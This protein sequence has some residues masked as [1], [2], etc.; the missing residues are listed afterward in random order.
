MLPRFFIDRPIFAW[1]IALGIL[2]AGILVFPKLPVSQYPDVAPPA[3][4]ITATYPGASAKVVEDTV[5]TLIEQEMNGI[6]NLLYMESNSDATGTLALTMTFATGTDLDI[7][8]VEAQNRIK[9]VESRL[10]EEVRRQGIVVTKARRNY[11]VFL[12]VFSPDQSRNAVDLG[13]FVAANVLDPIRR[14]PGVG[15]AQLFGT[16]YAM[17][18]WLDPLKLANYGMSPGQALAAV[19]AQ[20]VQLATGEL[21]QAP[22]VKGQELAATV[23]TRG[24]LSTPE[25]FGDIL[26]RTDGTGAAVHL[27]DVARIELGAQDYNIRARLNGQPAAAVGIKLA[28]G[29]NALATARAVQARMTELAKYF[30]E[31]ISWDVPY[32]TSRFVEISIREVAKTLGEAFLLVFLVMWLFL[33]KLRIAIIP[34]VVV[35]VSLVGTLVGLY[36]LGYSINV[37]TLF[38]MVL[39]IGIVVD[40]AIVVVENVERIMSREGLT[41]REATYKAMGQIFGAII[42]ITIV[43]SAVFV[44]MAFFSGSVGAIYRQFSVTLVTTMLFSALMALTLTPAMCATLLRGLEQSG[45]GHVSKGLLG[46]F[47]RFFERVT[48]GYVGGVSRALKGPLRMFAVYLAIVAGTGWLFGKLPTGFLPD[49]DQGYLI[50]M[51]QLPAGASQERTEK[52]LSQMEQFYLRQAEVE[53]VVGVLGFSF[54]G[55][56]QDAA[57]AF[58]RFKDWDERPGQ[59]HH[60]LTI[61]QRAN[62]MLYGIK[63]AM[64]FAVNPPSIPELAAVGGFDFRLQDQSGLGRGKLMEAR[65]QILGLASQDPRLVGIRPEGKEPA[66]QLFLD[67][68][69]VKA[70]S[71]GINLAE[72]NQTLAVALGSAYVNDFIRDGRVLRVVM[73]VDAPARA[74]PEGLLSLRVRTAQDTMVP[75]SEIATPHWTLDSPKLDRYNGVPAV[76]IVGNPAPGYSSG[77]AMQAMEELATKLPPG[78]GYEWSATS[79]EEKLSGTQAPI[80]FALSIVVV[81]LCLAALY[82]SWSVPLSVLLV[83]PLGVFGAVLATTLRDLPNDVYFK[84]GFIT[85]IGLSSKNAIL[86]VEFARQLEA[87]GKSTLEA[88]MGACRMRFRPI[89]MTSFAFLFGVLP[90]AI[91][92]GA[93]ASSRHAIGTGVMGGMVAATVLGVFL[94]PILYLLVRRLFPGPVKYHGA[95]LQGDE[96]A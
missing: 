79:Y 44:P 63:Q 49:E 54:L 11:L 13:S 3:L 31:G 12:T 9:R 59:E 94:I 26:L 85:I 25:Q 74:T 39:A 67:I 58:V 43:L 76:K 51:V 42:G 57:I 28:P 34:A 45:L 78:F 69:R 8:S 53:K 36:L 50:S 56:G 19:Q 41:A 80:L 1:V 64:I 23:I 18:I 72:L 14:V 60:A 84:V 61:V 37:L 90:L 71:L 83:V 82:E 48:G 86:I 87:Q 4:Q 40:D 10:P 16:E 55:K 65:N 81:F 46:W 93:G 22:A 75:L 29:S 7:A 5:T 91:S 73:Q 2:L 66:T 38:A 33:G 77:D 24:R 52:V 30:P 70:S 6:E 88:V 68:D 27:R 47:H 15:E 89:I 20:N 96:H 32:D 62:Q 35:P 21:G 92:T 17:R 95:A